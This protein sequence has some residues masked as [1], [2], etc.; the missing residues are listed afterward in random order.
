VTESRPWVD[1]LIERLTAVG[2]SPQLVAIAG[3]VTNLLAFLRNNRDLLVRWAMSS[4]LEVAR[5]LKL[6]GEEAATDTMVDHLDPDARNLRLSHNADRLAVLAKEAKEQIEFL[7]ELPEHIPWT[8]LF[9]LLA[10]KETEDG[11][12]SV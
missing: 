11:T 1:V 5:V 12:A 2:G 3:D 7:K 4:L 9:V 10:K 8:L 6:R